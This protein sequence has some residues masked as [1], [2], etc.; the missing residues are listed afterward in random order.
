[1]GGVLALALRALGWSVVVFALWFLAARPLSTAVAWG[2]AALLQAAAPVERARPRWSDPRVVFD[3]ELDG[4]TTFRNRIPAGAV[5]EVP[6]NPLRQTF[7]LP[8]FLALLLA[9]RPP[10][11]VRKAALGAAILLPLAALGVACEVA[12]DLGTV[13]AQGGVALVR[14]GDVAATL[15][16]LGYQLGTL[17]FPTVVPVMLW[18]AM[19]PRYMRTAA[20]RAGPANLPP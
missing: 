10:R 19:D 17:V 12:I 9:S 14:F 4:A 18:V 3:V 15:L 2:A 20:G 8:F 5:F 6:S 1:V 7:G 11:I 13:V 16:A